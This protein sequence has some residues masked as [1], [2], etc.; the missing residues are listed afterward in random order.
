[1]LLARLSNPQLLARLSATSLRAF[2]S[3]AAMHEIKTLTVFGAGPSFPAP[4][5][6][7]S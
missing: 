6:C 4:A 2:S 1:M 5:G 3:S 7:R